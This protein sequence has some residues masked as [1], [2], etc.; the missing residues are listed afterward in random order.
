[1]L[2]TSLKRQKKYA[3]EGSLI[4]AMLEVE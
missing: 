3:L 1:M 4:I 2:K